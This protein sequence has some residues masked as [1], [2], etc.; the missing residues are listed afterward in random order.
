MQKQVDINDN[1]WSHYNFVWS[2][3]CSKEIIFDCATKSYYKEITD[4]AHIQIYK[5]N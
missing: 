4:I 3:N 5:T 2:G 1:H